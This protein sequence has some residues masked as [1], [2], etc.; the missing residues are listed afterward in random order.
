[1]INLI[2][3]DL[4]LSVKTNIFAVFYS[5]F[6]A[7]M[8]T[9]SP[10]SL[11]SSLFY[12]LGIIMLVFISVIYTNGYDD[13][14][15]S[16]MV[17]NSL[18]IDKRNI[19]R[20]KYL[21]LLVFLAISCGAILLFTNIISIIGNLEGSKS[22]SVWHIIIGVNIVLI[23]YSIYYP[24]YFKLGE[25]IRSFNTVLWISVMIIPAFLSKLIKI[26]AEKGLLEK[27]LSIDIN[28][29]NIYLLGIS[30]IMYYISLQISKGIYMKREF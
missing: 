9:L 10:N 12:I 20:G 14:Y 5:V 21:M 1:M 26:L 11:I 22:V 3:K 8:G 2:K 19:V 17:L 28:T 7:V 13:K 30:F 24:F 4:M 16:E 29:I 15:K 18:P 27:I 23:F 6:I 25:G